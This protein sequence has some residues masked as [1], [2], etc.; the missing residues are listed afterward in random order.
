MG[1]IIPASDLSVQVVDPHANGGQHVGFT[2]LPVKVT[3]IPSG[4]VAQVECT[5]QHRA[6]LVAVRMIESA[7]T[8]PDYRP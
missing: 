3:H 4:I 1:D 7:L 6:R 8:D 5:S 2:R